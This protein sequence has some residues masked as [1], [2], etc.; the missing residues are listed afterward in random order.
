[1]QF[2]RTSGVTEPHTNSN[3]GAF[4]GCVSV[5]GGVSQGIGTQPLLMQFFALSSSKI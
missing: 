2:V 1:M 3:V 5:T 4:G